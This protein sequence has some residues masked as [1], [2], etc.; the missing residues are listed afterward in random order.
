MHAT[1]TVCD[2]VIAKLSPFQEALAARGGVF[3]RGDKKTF[4]ARVRLRAADGKTT[5][6]SVALGRD[7][8]VA[9]AALEII[10]NWR[11]QARQ[12]LPAVRDDFLGLLCSGVEKWGSSVRVRRSLKR[13]VRGL[14]DS[15]LLVE[16]VCM[17]LSADHYRRRPPGRPRKNQE[18]A[19]LDFG[20]TECDSF[21]RGESPLY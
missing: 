17:A 5:H 21:C 18:M 4:V 20:G 7:K 13:A 11:R 10:A 1:A 12:G 2:T 14:I 19:M 8:A 6:R 9:E 15:G 3:W 16:A